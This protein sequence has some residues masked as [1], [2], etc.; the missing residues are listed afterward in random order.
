MIRY[1]PISFSPRRSYRRRSVQGFV[2]VYGCG[3]YP[4]RLIVSW[5]VVQA[6]FTETETLLIP[7]M[8]RSEKITI[9]LS[10][11]LINR[12]RVARACALA[13][14]SNPIH[15]SGEE[16]MK[17]NENFYRTI[18]PMIG[19]ALLMA[20]IARTSRA[21][22]G[23]D[24]LYVGDGYDNTVKRFA[25][26]TGAYTGAFVP[27]GSDGQGW[28][29]RAARPGIHPTIA[30]GTHPCDRQSKRRS[31]LCWGNSSLQRHNR[32]VSESTRSPYSKLGRK[33]TTP[34]APAASCP[35]RSYL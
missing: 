29:R 3:R 28:P 32:D 27:P 24:F 21:D 34:F 1:R 23:R 12:N 2:R 30:L 26:N 17:N 13:Q 5:C 35:K 25:A 19:I 33:S 14:T 18:I 20:G 10:Q 7:E 22:D 15:H 9:M 31:E 16:I 8:Y 6:L 11:H 4:Q